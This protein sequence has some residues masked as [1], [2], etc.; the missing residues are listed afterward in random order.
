MDPQDIE[1]PTVPVKERILAA[2]MQLIQDQGIHAMTQAKVCEIAGVR[3]SH[4]TYYFPTRVKLL[5]EVVMRGT[6]AVLALLDGPEH[7]RVNSAAE[8]R[9]ALAEL[10]NNR[11]LPRMMVAV[12]V[13][14][15]EE[16]SLKPWLDKFQMNGLLRFK[17]ALEGIG[18]KPPQRA[19][20]AFLACLIGTLHN[21]F[22]AASERSRKRARAVIQYSFDQMV[23]ASKGTR[24]SEW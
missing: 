23:A 17:R 22:A 14:S 18:L 19:V 7:L 20:E 1:E 24:V 3:H 12:Y 8:L 9:T 15:D 16:P 13:A 5:K 21:D 2:A 10:P 4:L 6:E 11:G